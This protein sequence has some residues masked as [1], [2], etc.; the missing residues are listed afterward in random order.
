[1]SPDEREQELAH[2]WPLVSDREWREANLPEM[3]KE[4]IIRSWHDTD[5]LYRETRC[6]AEHLS[7]AHEN[8]LIELAWMR[9][10]PFWKLR[11]AVVR[12]PGVG[13]A[14]RRLKRR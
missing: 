14:V 11:E 1:M 13:R 3:T 12:V 2:W 4:G 8:A 6:R 10:S 9:D 7:E 5:I